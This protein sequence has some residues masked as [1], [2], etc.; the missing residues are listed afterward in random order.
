MES[1]S[2]F[3]LDLIRE[4]GSCLDWMEEQRFEWVGLV[5]NFL[6]RSIDGKTIIVS[7]DKDREWLASYI[8]AKLNQ[9]FIERP[10]LPVVSLI[11][12]FNFNGGI[13]LLSNN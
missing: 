6:S 1:L 10:L 3:T 11:N 4:H 7:T 2:S 5:A 8:I 13:Y 9:S 12:I